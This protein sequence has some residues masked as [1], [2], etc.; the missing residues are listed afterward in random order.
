MAVTG[1]DATLERA[2]DLSG[3]FVLAVSGA[4]LAA[5]KRFD[6]VGM[7]VLATATALGGGILRD[8]LLGEHPPAA[9]RGVAYLSLPLIATALV[10]VGHRLIEQVSRPVLVF[11]AGG[12]G[13]FCVVGTAKA[14]DAGVGV[15][16]AGVV[17]ARVASTR[18][19][20]T[21]TARSQRLS[22]RRSASAKVSMQTA[23]TV[24]GTARKK[25]PTPPHRGRRR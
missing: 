5:R 16:A 22:H 25:Y 15:L 17:A 9:L 6:V 4:S 19:A 7:A 2:L 14:L 1:L 24:M 11:D 23:T 13:L 8:T 20:N 18:A 12:L 3:I 21:G 10:L